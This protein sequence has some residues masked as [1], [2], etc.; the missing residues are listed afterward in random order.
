[1]TTMRALRYDD[2]AGRVYL[3]ADA[4]VPAP[5]DGEAL[6]RV[7]RAGVCATDL[8]ITRGYV[9]GYHLTLCHEFVG[10]VAACASRPELL[11]ARV[12]GE[13]NCGGAR[14]GCDAVFDRNHAPGRTVLGI[15]GRDGA[16]AEFLT[17][18][19]DNLRRVP[20]GLSDAEAC[21][22]EPLAAACRV[23]EQGLLAGVGAIAVVGDGKLGLLLAQALAEQAPGKARRFLSQQACR[24]RAPSFR[25]RLAR[26]PTPPALSAMRARARQT[27]F[28]TYP[29]HPSRPPQKLTTGR[30]RCSGGTPKRG[31]SS[32]AWRPCSR[33]RR[34]RRRATPAPLTSS[35]R[36][37]APARACAPRWRSPGRWA[38]SC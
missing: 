30:S 16:A 24:A 21:F 10:T 3:A 32:P 17:L 36:R 14:C 29:F 8:E 22:A 4:P 13:I 38:P 25:R 12:V 35:P 2:G 26:A 28:L 20:D 27:P 7:L 31:R 18:P 11:G 37:P 34:R 9:P 19:A 1:M 33:P 6:I 5:G 15:I 23:A